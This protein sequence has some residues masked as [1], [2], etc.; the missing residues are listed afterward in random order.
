M[1]IILHDCHILYGQGNSHFVMPHKLDMWHTALM[2]EYDTKSHEIK[3]TPT[4]DNGIGIEL[5][6][7]EDKEKIMREFEERNKLLLDG[8]WCQGWHDFC[9]SETYY[10]PSIGR[11]GRD[12]STERENAVFGH[13][14]D[15]EAHIDVWREYFLTYN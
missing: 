11:A 5:A 12:D 3:F 14:L 4:R 8:T 13:Y 7:G 10:V 6:K 2:V 15:C 1:L 9:M